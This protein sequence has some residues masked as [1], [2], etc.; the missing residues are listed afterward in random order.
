MPATK[1]SLDNAKQNKLFYF[2]GNVVVYRESDGRCLILKRDEREKV[3]PGR[4]GVPGGKLE[5]DDIDLNHPTRVNGGTVLDYNDMLETLLAREAREEA[6][7]EIDTTDFAY[8][9][10]LA[11]VRP[12]ETPV[13]MVKVAARYL[14]GEV[15]PEK[16]GFTEYAWVN[17]EEVKNY[18]CIDGIPEEVAKTVK[19]FS[20]PVTV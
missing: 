2:V 9:N 5:W 15:I 19:I 1:I 17:A 13:M 8:I 10:S 20:R 18:P 3:H 16:G 12:D 6:N 14:G 4:W 11:F 7:V